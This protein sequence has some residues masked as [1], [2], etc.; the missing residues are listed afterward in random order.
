MDK[1]YKIALSHPIREQ[2]ANV[3]L[4][5]NN[6]EL[7]NKSKNKIKFNKK[8]WNIKGN[9]PNFNILNKIR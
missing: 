7:D 6:F 9:I 8:I 5:L 1:K 4:N 3:I 2:L